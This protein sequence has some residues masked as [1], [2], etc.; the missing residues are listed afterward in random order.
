MKYQFLASFLLRISLGWFFFYA[1][2]SKL[3]AVDGFSAKGYLLNLKG[4]FAG[5]FLSLAGNVLVDQLVIWG[6]TLIGLCLILGI[7]IRF[8][9][10]WGIVMM[11]LFYLTAY[12]PA[13]AFLVDDHIIFIAILLFLMVSN[14]GYSYGFGKQLEKKFPKYKILMG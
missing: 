12:P 1:G 5:L 3:V 14:A 7:L 4:P 13:R 9:S 8:A 6:L 2:Y 11:A 10:F